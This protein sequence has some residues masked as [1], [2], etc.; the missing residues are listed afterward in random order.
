[1]TQAK[2]GPVLPARGT[3]IV[4]EV[5]RS[6]GQPLDSATRAYFEARFGQ[7][8]SRVRV[9]S[10]SAAEQSARA[11]SANAYTVGH[12]IVFDAGRLAP[13]RTRDGGCLPMS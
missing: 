7:D 11:M 4:H 10:G 6:P 1:M 8:F 13:G 9:H 5:L 12:N 2:M 3:S